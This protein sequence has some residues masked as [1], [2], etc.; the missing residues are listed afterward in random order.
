MDVTEGHGVR[1]RDRSA[2]GNQA[3]SFKHKT[4]EVFK[5]ARK[6]IEGLLLY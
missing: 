1:A 4:K 6:E 3:L 5:K 2:A